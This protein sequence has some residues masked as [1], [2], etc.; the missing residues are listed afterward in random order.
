MAADFGPYGHQRDL[1]VESALDRARHH[2]HPHRLGVRRGAGTGDQR[3]R[4][5]LQGLHPVLEGLGDARLARPRSRPPPTP[6]GW[7]SRSPADLPT[8]DL[9]DGLTLPEAGEHAARDRWQ[10]FLAD[11]VADYAEQRNRPDLPGTSRMS[12]HLKW[13][14]IHPRTMLADLEPL[15]ADETRGG[16]TTYRTELAWREFYADVLSARPGDRAR[17]P[18]PRVRRG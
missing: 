12:V 1:E 8:V 15:L 17:V 18:P 11:D 7:R 2:A 14:E 13:G 10:T 3:Q 4:R 9:P 5:S 6:T 16:A